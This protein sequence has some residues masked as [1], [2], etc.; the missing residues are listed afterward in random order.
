MNTLLRCFLAAI[1]SVLVFAA[2]P[3]AAQALAGATIDGQRYELASRRGRV[4]MVV[5]WRSDCPVCM[6]KLPE[7]RVNAQGWKH[8]PFDLVLVN[9]DADPAHAA[10]YERVRRV[11]APDER[12]VFSLWHGNV[13]MPANWASGARLPSTLIINRDGVVVERHQGRIP[14]AAWNLVADLLP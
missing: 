4:V 2:A 8:A 11:V 10:S 5:L 7:L 9:L 6:D 1:A 13:Q 3:V 12:A 14:P